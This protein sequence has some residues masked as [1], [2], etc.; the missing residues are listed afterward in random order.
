MQSYHT[1][2]HQII[3]ACLGLAALCGLALPSD[4]AT[5]KEVRDH[6]SQ[7]LDLKFTTDSDGDLKA[8]FGDSDIILYV[9]FNDARGKRISDPLSSTE[10]DQIRVMVVIPSGKFTA[11]QR[12]KMAKEFN[13]QYIYKLLETEDSD[14]L[15]LYLYAVE[16]SEAND[17]YVKKIAVSLVKNAILHAAGC[18]E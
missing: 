18:G 14:V 11:S 7:T 5:R 13:E 4:A 12:R 1:M 17:G 10:V 15:A 16:L 8:T 9:I 3:K 6:V 2:K